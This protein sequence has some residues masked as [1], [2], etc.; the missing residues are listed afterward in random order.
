M[1]RFHLESGPVPLHHQVYLHL[2]ATLES[3]ELAPGDRIAPERELATRYG[4]SVI[5][6][7][8]A[9]DEL[10]REGRVERTRGR[11]TFVLA[12][13]LDRD[14]AGTMSFAEEMRQRGLAPETR[15]IEARVEAAGQAVATALGLAMNVPIY[16]VTRLRLADGVPLLLEQANLPVDRFPDLLSSD[17]EDVS[18][19]EVLADRYGA[20]V[21]RT[22]EALEP[23]LLRGREARLL[24]VGPGKPALLIEGVAFIADGTPVEFS[25]SF[26]RGDRTRYYV[27]R[28][29]SR[30]SWRRSAHRRLGVA[31]GAH[32][33]RTSPGA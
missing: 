27:E 5:T 7:R 20:R 8:R 26:V 18:L 21:V 19:Y 22:R 25:R 3:G 9:L 28:D 23:V 33:V 24:D 12:P 29:V 16:V 2:V 32:H 13:K 14:I 31:A 30:E 1:A 11:G 6:I 10:A 15:L 4:C 17:L